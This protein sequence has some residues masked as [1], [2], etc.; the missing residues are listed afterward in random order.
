MI[1]E[2]LSRQSGLEKENLLSSQIESHREQPPFVLVIFGGTGDL[3][4]RKLIPALYNLYRENMLQKPFAILGISRHAS[5]EDE[6]RRVH[7]E[8]TSQ[9]SRTQ[10]IDRTVWDRFVENLTCIQGDANDPETFIQLK[11]RL[12]QIDRSKG[13]QGNRIFYF[14]TF[15]RMFPIILENLRQVGL[16]QKVEQAHEAPWTRIIFEK[17]FGTDYESAQKL[18]DKALQAMREHQI[19]RIDH[20]LGKETVQNILVM[21]FGNAIFEPLW[22][23]KYI[24]HIQITAAEDLGIESRGDFYDETGVIRDVVQNHLLEIMSLCA[25]EI[26]ITFRPEDI[27]DQKLL[28]LRSLQPIAGAAISKQVIAGQYERYTQ[29]KGVA[30]DSVTPTFACM[31]V[32]IDN[33]RWQGIPFYLRA[34]KKLKRRY[35]EVAIHFHSIPLCLFGRDDVCQMVDPNVLLLRIQPREGISLRFVCKEPGTHLSIQNVM[36]KFDYSSG[37]ARQI[38]EAYERLILD[39]IRGDLSLFARRDAI[40]TAWQFLDPTLQA[41]AQRRLPLRPYK[42]GSMGPAE[43]DHLLYGEGRRWFSDPETA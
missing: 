20:Y 23:R 8:S 5:V 2:E 9:Y 18:N 6:F 1:Q 42:A 13:T 7:F 17:P 39:C 28:L 22:N 32:M 38:A 30:A 37:F 24:D 4:R 21:R 3:A 41:I 10:P 35:T 12:E 34:G 36:M 15:P 33:W 14:S 26:P 40:E 31:K 19:Y 11:E 29:E 27:R 25:M 43:V 16:I